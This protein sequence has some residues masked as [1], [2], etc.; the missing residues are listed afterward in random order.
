MKIAEIL[1]TILWFRTPEPEL[2][3]GAHSV[4]AHR[5]QRWC[6]AVIHD[7]RGSRKGRLHTRIFAALKREVMLALLAIGV[8]TAAAFGAAITL[9]SLLTQL[10]QSDSPALSNIT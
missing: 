8:H 7:A 3:R 4:H 2:N 9:K 6:K 5:W 10:M 1:K